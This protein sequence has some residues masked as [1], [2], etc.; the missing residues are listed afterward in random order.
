CGGRELPGIESVGG[1]HPASGLA[2][3]DRRYDPECAPLLQRRGAGPEH[4]DPVVP[5]EPDCGH[6]RIPV[7]ALLRSPGRGSRTGRGEILKMWRGKHWCWAAA[8]LLLWA[9]PAFGNSWQVTDFHD[10][11]TVGGDGSTLVRE[12]IAVS[13]VGAWHGIHRVIPVSYPGPR[14]TNYDLILKVESVT[15]E[16]GHKLHYESKLAHGYRDLKIS[17]PGA[18]DATRTVEIDY[19]VRNGI[20]YFEDHDEFYWNVTGNDWPVPIDQASAVV[21]MPGAAAGLLRAQAFTGVYGSTGR[22]STSQVR[23]SEIFFETSSPLPMRGGLTI[24]I[25]IPKGILREPGA[26]TRLMW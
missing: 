9:A 19:I 17:I 10:D 20:R 8:W 16:N 24:D 1:V 21:H 7:A 18:E 23:G 4:E 12:R 22:E 14:G 5:H 25:F 15:D 6:V 2:E 26:F 11:I 13:F 3:P